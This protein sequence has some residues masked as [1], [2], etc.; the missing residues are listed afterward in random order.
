MRKINLPDDVFWKEIERQRLK[1]KVGDVEEQF[2][3]SYS[4]LLGLV[5]KGVSHMPLTRTFVYYK[6][7]HE[8]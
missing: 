6:M 3:F 8:A 1:N 5:F 2:V 7:L 4:L